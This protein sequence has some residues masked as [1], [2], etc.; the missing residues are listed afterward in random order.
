MEDV[1]KLI[2]EVVSMRNDIVYLVH[3]VERLETKI[4]KLE[5]APSAPMD[6]FAGKIIEKL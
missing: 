5:A 1:K 6:P 4:N 3:L 2:A